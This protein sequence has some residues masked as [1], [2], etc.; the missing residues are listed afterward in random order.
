MLSNAVIREVGPQML[1]DDTIHYKF[2]GSAGQSFGLL[3]R[4]GRN[5]RGRGRRH[6]TTLA[7][8]LSGGKLIIYPPK[9]SQF[10]AEENIL[11][12][13]LFCM[14][15]PAENAICAELP[16]SASAFVIAA[17]MPSSRASVITVANT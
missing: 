10:K 9:A 1:P 3:A 6:T 16:Q 8:A 2:F 17:P 14:A 13:T 12:G 5:A 4:Q 7:K 11:A 15:Q